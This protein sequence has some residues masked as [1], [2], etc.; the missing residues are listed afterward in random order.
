MT[1]SIPML[2]GLTAE[3]FLSGYWQKRPL[4]VR[5]A[6]PDARAL[7]DKAEVL[8][9]ATDEDVE[10]RLVEFVDGRWSLQKGPFSQAKL[11]RKRTHP[12]TVLVQGLNMLLPAADRLL[13]SLPFMPYA[14]LDDLMVSFAVPQ[15][16]VGP[17]FDTYD[18]FLIQGAGR[19]RWEIS[20]QDDLDILP[21][22]P[23]R[24]LSRFKAEQSWIVE[25]GD[26]LY[27]PPH[28]A[29]NGVALDESLTYSIGFRAP[30]AQELAT[31]FLG[32]LQER[33]TLE[34]RY[35]DPALQATAH[36]AEIADDM[37]GQVA[38]MLSSITWSRADV[39]R[40]VGRYQSEPKPNVFFSPPETPLPRRRFLAL[41]GSAGIELDRKTIL[42]FKDCSFFVNG[43]EHVVVDAASRKWLAELA[44]SRC[45]A[46]GNRPPEPLHDLLHECYVAGFL[47][48]RST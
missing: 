17:H 3:Q 1:G 36:P 38:E 28:Y 32:Y 15:A 20:A 22:I 43:E 12:W 11:R 13:R 39:M 44:D 8:Q 19:R 9:F 30:S 48:P 40:F 27:L 35:Q 47:W 29:H 33:L 25:P 14:R 21:D 6:V 34:G 26:L 41:C 7:S 16:G 23:I 18:V 42:L 4:L 24:I 2:G 46:P 5:N 31:E 10:S 45:S 37:V